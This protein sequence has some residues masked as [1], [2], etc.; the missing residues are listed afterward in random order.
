M[1]PGNFSTD[2]RTES[3]EEQEKQRSVNVSN[4]SSFFFF[5]FPMSFQV[6]GW[7]CGCLLCLSFCIALSGSPVRSCPGVFSFFSDGL[8]LLV[9]FF[10]LPFVYH[11]ITCSSLFPRRRYA[12]SPLCF[13]RRVQPMFLHLSAFAS[14][15]IPHFVFVLSVELWYL[16]S[17]HLYYSKRTP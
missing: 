6:D 1:P 3:T 17:G 7:C 2:Q 4:V 13:F 16:S 9:T 11:S 15:S 12:L 10:F 8:L 14:V 5:F